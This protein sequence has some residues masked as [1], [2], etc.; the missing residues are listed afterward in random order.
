MNVGVN[1]DVREEPRHAKHHAAVKEWMHLKQ[2]EIHLIQSQTATQRL[3][4]G[5]GD[6]SSSSTV[7]EAEV[8]D[9]VI[10][11]QG[12]RGVEDNVGDTLCPSTGHSLEVQTHLHFVVKFT[13]HFIYFYLPP[14][15]EVSYQISS[16]QLISPL[17]LFPV[18]NVFWSFM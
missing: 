5:L 1:I 8:E 6:A 17:P 9:S 4:Q 7:Q 18:F 11:N 16:Y 3:N 10:L 15:K 13:F 12:L 14:Q 2:A